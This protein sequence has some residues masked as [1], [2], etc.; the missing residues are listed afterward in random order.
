MFTGVL[1][2]L[3][4]LLL[5]LFQ[6]PLPDLPGRVPLLRRVLLSILHE[7]LSGVRRGDLRSLSNHQ[8]P[9]WPVP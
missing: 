5:I 6:Q 2:L 8:Q 4:V 7:A 1:R 9:R 3:H